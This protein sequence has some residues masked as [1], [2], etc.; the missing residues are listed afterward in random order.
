MGTPVSRAGTE[1]DMVAPSREGT[2]GN[3]KGDT[4]A[5]REDMGILISSSRDGSNNPSSLVAAKA[6]VGFA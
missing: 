5:S 2:E 6:Q 4:V 1:V 3:P